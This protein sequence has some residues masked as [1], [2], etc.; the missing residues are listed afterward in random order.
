MTDGHEGMGPMH[1][2]PV[3][4][5]PSTGDEF[6]SGEGLVALAG[7]VLLAVWVLFDVFLDDY[8]LNI[9][10]LLL[11]ATVV[12]VPRLPR[13]SVEKVHPVPVVMKTAGYALALVGAFFII[14]A[15]ES[16]FYDTGATIIAALINYVAYGLAFLGAR[17][18]EI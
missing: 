9:L 10:E 6:T 2:E 1:E 7:M 12:I 11:A 4:E 17:Q 16:G 13:E 14:S 18:I 3:S 5:A 15:L 8:G